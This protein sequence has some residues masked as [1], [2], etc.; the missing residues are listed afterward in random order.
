MSL[1][2]SEREREKESIE[3]MEALFMNKKNRKGVRVCI[4]MAIKMTF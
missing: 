3:W 4:S 1:K 2:E